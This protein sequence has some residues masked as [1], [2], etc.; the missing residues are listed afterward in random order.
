MRMS[1]VAVHRCNV[2]VAVVLARARRTKPAD[3]QRQDLGTLES[4]KLA[5]IILVDGIPWST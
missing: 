5:D 3:Y 4:G 2:R 1:R